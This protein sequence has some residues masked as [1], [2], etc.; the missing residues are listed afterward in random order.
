MSRLVSALCVLALA[1]TLSAQ[2]RRPQ[3]GDALLR[4]RC[5]ICHDDALIAQQRLSREGWDR[6]I[7]KMIGWGAVVAPEEKPRLLDA[8]AGTRAGRPDAAQVLK[9]RCSSCHDDRLIRQQRLSRDGWRRELE[10]MIGWG[11]VLTTEERNTL[12]DA[13]AEF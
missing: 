7:D 2:E 9:T 1:A 3:S 13:L 12:A 6:E 5:L 10:K 11:A 4:A 8:L